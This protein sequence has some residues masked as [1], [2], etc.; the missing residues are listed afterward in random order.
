MDFYGFEKKPKNL[1]QVVGNIQRPD[2][3]EWKELTTQRQLNNEIWV[4]ILIGNYG[5]AEKVN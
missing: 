2:R 5:K 3:I 4:N 1:N